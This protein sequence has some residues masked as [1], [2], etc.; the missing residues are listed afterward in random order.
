VDKPSLYK[1][2]ITNKAKST[3]K[4]TKIEFTYK[5][6]AKMQFEPGKFVNLKCANG[7][8]RAYS[9]SSDYK[10]TESMELLIE[11]G[12]DGIGANYVRD[13]KKGDEIEIIGP[14]G[15]FVL[16][17]P[18]PDHLVFFAT[19]TGIAPFFAM[20]YKL[21]DLNYSGKIDLFIG[22]RTRSLII[23]PELIDYFAKEL[24]NFTAKIYLSRE[25]N[26]TQ[27]DKYV[28]GRVTNALG[29]VTD[30]SAQYYICGHPD[31][32]DFVAAQLEQKGVPQHNIII[33]GFT[34]SRV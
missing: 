23:E 19:G 20:F 28:A 5:E 27:T 10:K 6:P 14:S 4:V 34:H 21:I 25:E 3:D 11:T 7:K 12:H 30:K 26:L 31:M 13:I 2:I 15:K 8:Y 33:E 16:N 29:I 24:Q 1:A 9:I 18:L 32:V 22:A 17:L